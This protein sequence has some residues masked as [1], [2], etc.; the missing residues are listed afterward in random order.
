MSLSTTD[1]MDGRKK[2]AKRI[3]EYRQQKNWQSFF[4]TLD[5]HERQEAFQDVYEEMSPEDYWKNLGE[6]IQGE[7]LYNDELKKLLTNKSKD[8]SLRHLMMPEEDKAIL[9]NL[10]KTFSIYRGADESN[11]GQGWSWSLSKQIAYFFAKRFKKGIVI[12]GKCAKED[13]IAYFNDRKEQE[14][15]IPYNKV[16]NIVELEKIENKKIQNTDNVFFKRAFDERDGI[17]SNYAA[18]K[19]SCKKVE[20]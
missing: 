19:L 16:R 11:P 18:Y 4:I 7:C 14:I 6:I 3:A 9:N 8:L 20:T 15:V 17:I 10:S 12:K 1:I 2:I 13:I 5:G